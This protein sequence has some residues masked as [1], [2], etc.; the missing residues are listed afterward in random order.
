MSK[1][2]PIEYYDKDLIEVKKIIKCSLCD[3]N[4]LYNYNACSYCWIHAQKK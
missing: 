4:A 1:T 2:I 3:R